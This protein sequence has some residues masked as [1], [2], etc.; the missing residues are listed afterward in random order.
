MREIK[1]EYGFDSVNVVVKKSY[2]LHEIP[3]IQQ[4]CDV[5]NML[6]IK[7]VRQYTGVK[8]F[9]KKEIYDGDILLG[10]DSTGGGSE[11]IHYTVK[12]VVSWDNENG[13]WIVTE[14][15][16]GDKYDLYDY[17]LTDT[18]IGNVYQNPE[19]LK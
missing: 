10:R 16:S 9:D 14:L 8:S 13:K 11:A 6:P 19:L 7:Y 3:M 5:W 15:G 17:S 1:F 2:Y 12:S 4:K 18:V